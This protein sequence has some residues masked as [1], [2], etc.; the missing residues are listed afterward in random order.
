MRWRKRARPRGWHR[1]YAW[2]PVLAGDQWIWLETVERKS[3][4]DY[5]GLGYDYR[6]IQEN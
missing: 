5:D 6:P 4:L 1:W 3:Y 2:H